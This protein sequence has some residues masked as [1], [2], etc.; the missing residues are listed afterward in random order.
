[1]GAKFSD[2]VAAALGELIVGQAFRAGHEFS[3]IRVARTSC[4]NT[5]LHGRD[6]PG[7][8]QR[9]EDVEYAAVVCQLSI[10]VT[11]AFPRTNGRQVRWTQGGNLPLVDRVVRDPQQADATVAPRL[12]ACPFDAVV[13]VL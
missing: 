11:R 10:I 13:I 1:M 5:V 8:P 4:A 2:R 6:L 7:I 9:R 12:N 3:R